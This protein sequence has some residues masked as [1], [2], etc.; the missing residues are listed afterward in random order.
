MYIISL[1]LRCSIIPVLQRGSENLCSLLGVSQPESI[2][3]RPDYTYLSFSPTAGLA[4][5]AR[6]RAWC[7]ALLSASCHDSFL[8]TFLNNKYII[9]LHS[10]PQIM[11]LVLLLRQKCFSLGPRSCQGCCL[12][13]KYPR[14]FIYEEALESIKYFGKIYF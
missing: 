1:Q 14:E 2:P 6:L 5:W 11:S 8:N 9:I 10:A 4:P 13:F 12:F 3:V 7:K